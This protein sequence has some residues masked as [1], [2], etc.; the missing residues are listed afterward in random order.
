M[1]NPYTSYGQS[2]EDKKEKKYGS[3][4]TGYT[5]R[6]NPYTSY[7]NSNADVDDDEL[8]ATERAKQERE[9]KKKKAEEDKK[10][11]EEKNLLEKGIDLGVGLAKEIGSQGQKVVGTAVQ[12]GAAVVGG[13][14]TAIQVA[15]GDEEGTKKSAKRTKDNIESWNKKKTI[16]G[17][18]MSY[19]SKDV[20]SGKADVA[21]FGA[22]FT[23]AGVDTAGF[24]M[25]GVKSASVGKTIA[26]AAGVEGI[27]GF[28]ADVADQYA[29]TGQVDYKQ[30]AM[31]GGASAIL[32]GAMGGIGAQ[33]NK[34]R[35]PK[36]DDGG[37]SK[38]N[39]TDEMVSAIRADKKTL[40]T[41][42]NGKT[43]KSKSLDKYVEDIDRRMTEVDTPEYQTNNGLLN[44]EAAEARYTEL[45]ED[46]DQ[47]PGMREASEAVT[48]AQKQI[49]YYN[50][51]R[52]KNPLARKVDTRKEKINKIESA[53]QQDL[54]NL[55]A[56]A[57]DVESGFDPAG[58]ESLVADVNR[59]YD[60]LVGVEQAKIDEMFAKD[61][62]AAAEVQM[63]DASEQ[64]VLQQRMDA[65]S[66]INEVSANQE[67]LARQESDKI[68]QTPNEE[69][70]A[71]HKAYLETK[72]K[73]LTERLEKAEKRAEAPNETLEHT[74]EE[75]DSLK[76]GSHPL[77]VKNASKD[78]IEK[79]YTELY[80]ENQT[81]SAEAIVKDVG[82]TGRTPTDVEVED[83]TAGVTNKYMDEAQLADKPG[84]ASAFNFLQQPTQYL[85]KVGLNELADLR[86]DAMMAHAKFQMD[87]DKKLQGYV[88]DGKKINSDQIFGALNGDKTAYDKLSVVGQ[89][90]VDD[91]R[92]DYREVG[93]K[94]GIPE[95]YIDRVDYA[96][97]LFTSDGN[98]SELL[99]LQIKLAKVN[100]ALENSVDGVDSA[101]LK[102]NKTSNRGELLDPY[103]PGSPSD[104]LQPTSRVSKRDASGVL[105]R[106]GF[107]SDEIETIIG[108]LY[109]GSS[110]TAQFGRIA[111]EAQKFDDNISKANL[112]YNI[113]S[114]DDFMTFMNDV[115]V[116]SSKVDDLQKVIT[117][118]DMDEIK[119]TYKQRFGDDK[120]GTRKA[121]RRE[122]D[123]NAHYDIKEDYVTLLEGKATKGTFNH[124]T[125]H[126]AIHQF[127][128]DKQIEE[129][130]SDIVKT[131]GGKKGLV[132][133]YQGRGYEDIS[134]RGAAEEEIA[135]T[136]NDFLT[137]RSSMS[138]K[139]VIDDVYTWAESKNIP[140]PV[141]KILATLSKKMDEFT[142]VTKSKERLN[143]FYSDIES[144]KF[145]GAERR[146]GSYEQPKSIREKVGNAMIDSVSKQ[147]ESSSLASVL[148]GTKI[149]DLGVKLTNSAPSHHGKD[150]LFE[151]VTLEGKA[152]GL[153]KK[154]A[155]SIQA[156]IDA[157][158]DPTQKVA[159]K[160]F[161]KATGNVKNRFLEERK[162]AEGYETNPYKA[163]SAY[164]DAA[165]RKINFEPFMQQAAIVSN[166]L[167]P[168][169]TMARFLKEEVRNM[170]NQKHQFDS[171]LDDGFN[172]M[173]ASKGLDQNKLGEFL[174]NGPTKAL[175]GFRLTTS[176]AHLGMSVN[177]AI[178]TTAQGVFM[179]GSF[180]FDGTAVGMAKAANL[181]RK[182]AAGK[183]TKAEV[184]DWKKMK[185]MGV[186]EGTSRI[187]PE[188]YEHANIGKISNLGSNAM[189]GIYAG[190]IGAD[191]SLRMASYYGAEY[192]GKQ[193]GLSGKEL[194]RYIYEKV[195]ETNQNFGRY[196]APQ[197]W[198]SHAA[199]MV[200]SM[201]N[202]V[203]GAIIRSSEIAGEGI[204]GAG[205]IIGK[206]GGKEV[207][208]GEY[209]DAVRGVSNAL[210]FTMT[211]AVAAQAYE[212]MTG[213]GEVI[214]NPFSAD[215][216]SNPAFQ[217]WVGNADTGRAGFKDLFPGRGD[218]FD[219]EGNN[220]T[221]QEN[222]DKFVN[223][224]LPQYFIPGYSQWKRTT[225]AMKINEQGYSETEKGRIRYIADP[226]QDGKRL[227]TGE[228]S[229][230]EGREYIENMGQ[231][232]GGSLQADQSDVVKYGTDSKEEQTMYYDFYKA[233]DRIT[234]RSEA[235]K[236]V[237]ALYEKGKPEAAKRKAKEYNQQVEDKLA[238]WK[239]QYDYL[240]DDVL[241]ELVSG[242][243]IELT[244]KSEA[245][246][247]R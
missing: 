28:G 190:V 159:Y 230:P 165:N 73:Q 233:A 195:I 166:N 142:G 114:D 193:K 158:V 164:M 246:R 200:G 78:T 191:R 12:G 192:I 13:I 74:V 124:E 33:F 135:N 239:D 220:V 208:K 14:D 109:K 143:Q 21:E 40:A 115:D 219:E 77:L 194:D 23:K 79:R 37:L 90:I 19:I 127:L 123:V 238:T 211:A 141:L 234:S 29:R 150:S 30:A 57:S 177:T 17:D 209:Y 212:S 81:N 113:S 172:Q 18:E 175:R 179:P 108:S 88:K 51:L 187:I 160:D 96:P 91:M 1:A 24:V 147:D 122:D 49:D 180:G 120:I 217:F 157:L 138:K 125:V 183:F 93:I 11:K 136:F 214:P 76:D 61:P 105:R 116:D 221:L 7:G 128:D 44:V 204:K 3:K 131:R 231:P 148:I 243:R 72:K 103:L 245:A 205:T 130:Y 87:V 85:R 152:L 181:T 146:E 6:S 227:L 149:N 154:Q 34:S 167:E 240:D 86:T 111:G 224:T 145:N 42:E 189:K 99:Q 134:W 174:K 75:L 196:E 22:G 104:E 216:W 161:T 27:L 84:L 65:E 119:E 215:F 4:D 20:Q 110:K 236:E 232:G 52:L 117:P 201:I 173:L 144:G 129:L 53:R 45:M 163:Y 55:Q 16:T 25:P 237:T 38:V 31:S 43:A 89:K 206:Y 46:I 54:E 133:D 186:H 59:Q 156:Q 137:Y 101:N 182:L 70:I 222:R 50:G 15:Q 185:E 199:K 235:N 95:E 202:F 188:A 100:K 139:N 67:K 213:Q 140:E 106:A 184:A 48:E 218:E 176:M 170:S 32:G 62:E 71:E 229:T 83:M 207:T 5:T 58:L 26:T 153:A 162:G 241:E 247:T 118:E 244:S 56:M 223:E 225:N 80:E 94:L 107:E 47:I 8:S 36:V 132:K 68:A 198:R 112:K 203:P 169:S 102:Y 10:K 69:K 97:H 197:A 9:A 121:N 126:K 64:T 82:E 39:V 63:L 242:L 41:V 155:A 171:F 168:G 178:N 66:A 60:E 210:S 2:K 151:K 92:K 226:E 98:K 228:Y 35:L